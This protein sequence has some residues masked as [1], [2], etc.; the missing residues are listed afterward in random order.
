MA[1]RFFLVG[2][3][4]LAASLPVARADEPQYM[5]IFM[6]DVKVGHAVSQRKVAGAEVTHSQ[7]MKLTIARGSM[8]MA[9]TVTTD[10]TE[11]TAGTPLRFSYE[12]M[13]GGM[14]GMKKSGVIRNGQMTVTTEQFG[15][16]TEQTV[17][18]P[19]GALMPEAATRLM[20]AK[21]AKPGTKYTYVA[22]DPESL[23]GLKTEVLIGK[24][25]RVPLI[26]QATAELIPVNVTV[27]HQGT[28]L[29]MQMFF[30]KQFEARKMEMSAMHFFCSIDS[31]RQ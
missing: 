9:V 5:A 13:L 27:N 12:A 8:A 17:P 23:G 2:L 3:V 22:F 1:K 14:G 19:A 16:P 18:Y 29:A 15:T 6:D 10:M 28:P 4:F 31:L 26:G 20:K 7:T 25:V 30:D 21:G 11:T 24:P